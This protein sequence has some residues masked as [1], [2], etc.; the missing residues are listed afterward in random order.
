[1]KSVP[2]CADIP[3]A[4]TGG[5]LLPTLSHNKCEIGEAQVTGQTSCLHTRSSL[6]P[7]ATCSYQQPLPPGGAKRDNLSGI[8]IPVAYHSALRP[9]ARRVT[10]ELNSD[11]KLYA[12][13]SQRSRDVKPSPR[14][15]QVPKS[16]YS[17]AG[18][19]APPPSSSSFRPDMGGDVPLVAHGCL[20]WRSPAP[21]G[22]KTASV[23]PVGFGF[24][25]LVSES[26]DFM[27]VDA[28]F[29]KGHLILTNQEGV[30]IRQLAESESEANLDFHSL[31]LEHGRPI[32]MSAGDLS[33]L[34]DLEDR[35]A[36]HLSGDKEEGLFSKRG[37]VGGVKAQEGVVT[38]QE[39]GG[40]SDEG[41]GTS[42]ENEGVVT[43]QEGRVEAQEQKGSAD[44][45]A[46]SPVAVGVAMD[47]EGGATVQV[48]D[49]NGETVRGIRAPPP[50]AA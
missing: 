36:G 43:P 4:A 38:S 44:V 49:D 16:R 18:Q 32:S 15:V 7:K 47:T 28:K 33:P 34:L 12:S 20:E 14:F 6:Q 30:V 19:R 41:T 25:H 46:N 48:G 40:N 3:T 1:M 31:S 11:P 23:L 2:R 13:A 35:E 27:L 8:R 45:E 39:G 9:S 37:S 24:Q 21:N 26:P 10:L 50:S 17:A 42:H 29:A 5:Y 22:N